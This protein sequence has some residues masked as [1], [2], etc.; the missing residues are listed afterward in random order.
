METRP[1]TGRKKLFGTNGIRGVPN[2]DLTPVFC[3]DIA[4]AIGTFSKTGTV[5]VGRDTRLSGDMI[6]SSV[7]AGLLSTGKNVIDLGIL[8]TPALQLYCKKNKVFGVII[9]ASHNPPQFNGIKCIDS[10]GTELSQEDE[11]RIEDIYYGRNYEICEWNRLGRV[12]FFSGQIAEYHRSIISQVNAEAIIRKH[13]RVVVDTGNGAA[14]SS[15]PELLTKLG[16]AVTTLNANPDGL[17]TSRNAEPRPENLSS[18]IDLM[19]TGRFDLGIAHDGDADRAVFVDEVGN[20][21]EGEKTLALAIKDV[22]VDGDI[23]VTPV[24]SSDLISD[25]C[26]TSGLRLVQTRVGA[27]IVARKMIDESAKIGGEENGGIIFGQHQYCRDGGMTAAKMLDIM[28]KSGKKISYL[29]AELPRYTLL[30]ESIHTEITW[31][32]LSSQIRE[33]FK[34]HRI[35]FTDG[36]KIYFPTGWILVRPSG[37]EPIVRI[38]SNARDENNAQK[39]STTFKS[40]LL[41]ITGSAS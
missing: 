11:A 13:F 20:F 17:F 7:K 22:A 39:L 23:V 36:L 8:P 21:I 28:A 9:T 14:Y 19:K 31:E 6:L 10:D 1:K 16:C 4:S 35:D 40:A 37:T 30:K 32:K 12:S 3:S 34:S 38:Y 25:I 27:P 29:V 2:V 26:S 15:T 5:A 41:K 33:Y 18:L 24:S